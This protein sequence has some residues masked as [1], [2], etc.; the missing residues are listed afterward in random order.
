MFHSFK[1]KNICEHF[2]I[3]CA[4]IICQYIM[5]NMKK[6]IHVDMDI[7]YGDEISF[8]L[9]VNHENLTSQ[10]IEPYTLVAASISKLKP[11]SLLI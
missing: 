11:F 8:K 9:V 6:T 1:K 4:T 10:I 3:K 2:D 7:E 5:T